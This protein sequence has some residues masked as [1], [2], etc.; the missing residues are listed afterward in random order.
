MTDSFAKLMT[1]TKPH[2]QEPQVIQNRLNTPNSTLMSYHIQT[3]A[4]KNRKKSLK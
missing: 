3:E 1:D 4:T 2:I